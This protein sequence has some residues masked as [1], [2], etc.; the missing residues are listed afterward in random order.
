ML[1]SVA[2]LNVNTRTQ[3]TIATLLCVSGSVFLSEGNPL[4]HWYVSQEVTGERHPT[5]HFSHPEIPKHRKIS[6]APGP[7]H[8]PLRLPSIVISSLSCPEKVHP[9]TENLKVT[10]PYDGETFFAIISLVPITLLF[11]FLL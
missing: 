1:L 5:T 7:L 9:T 2:S 6:H 3:L 10:T 4:T 8:L 11:T